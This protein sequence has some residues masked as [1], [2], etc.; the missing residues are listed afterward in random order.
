MVSVAP[1]VER[2]RSIR[3][4]IPIQSALNS[5]KPLA[6]WK[7]TVST[8]TTPSVAVADS[9]A[10]NAFSSNSDP[11]LMEMW[12]ARCVHNY[13]ALHLRL[14]IRVGELAEAAQ[15]NLGNFNRAFRASFGYTPREYVTRMRIAR[16]QRLMAMSHH[17]LRQIAVECGFVDQYDFKN[18]FRKVVGQPP[19]DWRARC[20]T[21]NTRTIV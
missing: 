21:S 10:P 12:Q 18:H 15:L 11:E 2:S 6:P 13:V 19:A 7:A 1:P 14:R 9:P 17:S 5:H 16:A 4:S 8:M 3:D 20:G